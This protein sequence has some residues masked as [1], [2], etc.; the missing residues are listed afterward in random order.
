[1]AL[2]PAPNL[3]GFL[4]R[5]HP[6]CITAGSLR[7][8]EQIQYLLPAILAVAGFDLAR[9]NKFMI[10]GD[11]LVESNR[12]GNA[13]STISWREALTPRLNSVRLHLILFEQKRA[14]W[15]INPSSVIQIRVRSENTARR[16]YNSGKTYSSSVF[17][18]LLWREGPGHISDCRQKPKLFWYAREDFIFEA[19]LASGKECMSVLP[20][21]PNL[22][23]S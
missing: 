6:S 22:S 1:M 15:T 19:D 9:W 21:S 8:R 12:T 11:C 18:R 14:C 3:S 17:A 2:Q 5:R 16:R 7:H 10:I 4:R 23:Y 13:W 20:R